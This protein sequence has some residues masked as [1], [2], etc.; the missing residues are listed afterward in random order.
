MQQAVAELGYR[1]SLS[2]RN[3]ARGRS[4]VVALAVPEIGLPYFAELAHFM[5]IEAEKRDWTLVVEQTAHDRGRELAVVVERRPRPPHRRRADVPVRGLRRRRAVRPVRP[6]GG[7][8]RQRVGG[9][10]R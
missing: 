1:P 3:L 10:R 9:R 2:A 4:G 8:V 7:A 6:A 5:M